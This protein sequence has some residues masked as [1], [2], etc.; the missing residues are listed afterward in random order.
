MPAYLLFFFSFN[1]IQV[2]KIKVGGEVVVVTIIKISVDMVDT[3]RAHTANPVGVGEDEGATG[4]TRDLVTVEVVNKEE[5]E[6]VVITHL[7]IG[8]ISLLL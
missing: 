3:T 8:V 2:G 1:Q 5:E 7:I 6:E 4:A